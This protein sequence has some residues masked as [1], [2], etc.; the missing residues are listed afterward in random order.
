MP[1]GLGSGEGSGGVGEGCEKG[2]EERGIRHLTEHSAME[3]EEQRRAPAGK[4]EHSMGVYRTQ[5]AALSTLCMNSLSPFLMPGL[6]YYCYHL[7]LTGE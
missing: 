7:P 6:G 1:G 2:Q 4:N 5:G 3:L